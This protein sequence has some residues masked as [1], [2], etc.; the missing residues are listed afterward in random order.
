MAGARAWGAEVSLAV[1]IGAAGE[2]RPPGASAA[3]HLTPSCFETQVRAT[4]E[5][6][7]LWPAFETIAKR[8]ENFLLGRTF[9]QNPVP[10][11]TRY[12]PRL[13]FKARCR[14]PSLSSSLFPPS[15]L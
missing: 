9:K 3:C 13:C 5:Q 15:P 7:L 11:V 10:S 4:D 12:R 1:R 2:R 6:H 14:Y 8:P